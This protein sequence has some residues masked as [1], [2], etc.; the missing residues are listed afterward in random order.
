MVSCVKCGRYI[1][2]GQCGNFANI[3]GKAKV[4]M[5]FKKTVSVEQNCLYADCDTLD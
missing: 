3:N 5:Y 2:W 1:K 4:I